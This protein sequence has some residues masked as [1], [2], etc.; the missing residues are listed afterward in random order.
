MH[1]EFTWGASALGSTEYLMLDD[2]IGDVPL[3]FEGF[4]A[5]FYESTLNR[6]AMEVVQ[7]WPH[8]ALHP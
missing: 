6:H 7:H 2:R 5:P 3:T 4:A 8:V 1:L